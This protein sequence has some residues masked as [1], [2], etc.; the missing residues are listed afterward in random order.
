MPPPWHKER[1][2]SK[3]PIKK[4]P[5]PTI[6]RH[7]NEV[8]SEANGSEVA[9]SK[10]TSPNCN[11][12]YVEN[13]RLL[14]FRN[15]YRCKHYHYQNTYSSRPKLEKPVFSSAIVF[16]SF[17]SLCS[18]SSRPQFTT[19]SQPMGCDRRVFVAQSINGE[20]RSWPSVQHI[21][22]RY[23]CNRWDF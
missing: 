20:V 1:G 6:Q 17:P 11:P 23:L 18:G 8:W 19:S 5:P 13:L 3:N 15:T 10:Q 14:I 7:H 21:G 4:Q 9:W 22:W 2:H 12:K 16:S